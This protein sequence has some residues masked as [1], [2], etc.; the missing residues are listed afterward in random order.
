MTN[1]VY[2]NIENF[3]INKFND[4]SRKRPRYGQGKNGGNSPAVASAQRRTNLA[5]IL[6]ATQP[7]IIVVVEVSSGAGGG[8]DL[9]T[10][11]GGLNGASYIL[12][13][14]RANP[15]DPNNAEWRLV[16]PLKVGAGGL[17]ESV[18]VFYRGVSGTVGTPTEVQRYFTGPNIWTGANVSVA[19]GAP[20]PYPGVAV[21]WPNILEFLD[22]PG[23]AAAR[24]IPVGAQYNGN[25]AE[26]TVAARISFAAQVGA[27]PAPPVAGGFINYNGL[28]QPYMVSFV[29]EDNTGAITRNLTIIAVHSPPNFIGATNYMNVLLSGAADV[30]APPDVVNHNEIK[31]V[32]GDFNLNAITALGARTNA[33]NTLVGLNYTALLYPPPA[34][35]GGIAL[36]SYQGYLATHIKP[37]RRNAQRTK[38]SRFLWSDNTVG[39]PVP[40]HYPGYRYIGSDIVNNFFSIDNIL[41]QPAPGAPQFTIMNQVTGTPFNLVGGLPVGV[42]VGTRIMPHGLTNLPL[43]PAIP[44]AGPLPIAW[45][46]APAPNYAAGLARSLNGWSNYGNLRGTSD[47]LALFASI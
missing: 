16:P 46:Q 32:C 23:A 2:W 29:E 41:V 12:D 31:I 45:P 40:S 27:I 3:G 34:L 13:L 35:P 47:H 26:S 17:T 22:P 18:A 15:L 38:N 4:P 42:P 14:L 6:N 7:D 5:A 8:G 33:Y 30:A 11:T 19:A 10:N 24:N 37:A 36:E 28:R 39:A 9:A 43:A 20:A 21:G 25:L 44:P 1:I